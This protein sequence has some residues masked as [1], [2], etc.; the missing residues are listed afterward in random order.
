MSAPPGL[1]EEV[2]EEEVQEEKKHG[3]MAKIPGLSFAKMIVYSILVAIVFGIVGSITGQAAVSSMLTSV[4]YLML[5]GMFIWG[6][7]MPDDLREK[8]LKSFKKGSNYW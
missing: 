6:F 4:A 2:Q 7:F 1:E 3:F 8:N 5:L